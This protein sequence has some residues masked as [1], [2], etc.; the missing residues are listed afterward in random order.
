MRFSGTLKS[1]AF[2]RRR[3]PAPAAGFFDEPVSE[4]AEKAASTTSLNSQTRARVPFDPQTYRCVHALVHPVQALQPVHAALP[5][6]VSRLQLCLV[7][8]G[9]DSPVGLSRWTTSSARQKVRIGRQSS[10]PTLNRALCRQTASDCALCAPHIAS[11]VPPRA[12]QAP[13]TATARRPRCPGSPPSRWAPPPASLQPATGR[14][15]RLKRALPRQAGRACE[16]GASGSHR[17]P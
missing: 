12:S 5:R 14:L 17:W 6:P 11:Q 4:R 10:N 1:G 7:T 3:D 2:I 8:A 9:F 13:P 16:H 15:A